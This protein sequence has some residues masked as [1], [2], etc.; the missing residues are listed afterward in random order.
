M[1][2]TVVP[3]E[4]LLQYQELQQQRYTSLYQQLAQH[5]PMAQS[6]YQRIGAG[7]LGSALGGYGTGSST[8][9]QGWQQAYQLPL[10]QMAYPTP[11]GK[12]NYRQTI[13]FNR[14]N[15][16]VEINGEN[17]EDERFSE[18]LDELRIKVATWLY[19]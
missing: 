18:P 11:M 19:N 17:L 1:P 10:T 5:P 7:M 4:L 15:E 9:T 2:T 16:V 6:L 3:N 12:S 13:R 14:I 8:G